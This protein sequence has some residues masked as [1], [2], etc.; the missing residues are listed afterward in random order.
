[1]QALIIITGPSAVGKTT[2]AKLLFN[3]FSNLKSAVTYTTREPRT[4]SQEDKLI[5]HVTKNE[6]KALIKNNKLIEWAE[7][8]GEFYG[9]GKEELLNILEQSPVLLNIDVQGAKNIKQ[10]FPESLSFFIQ[11]DNL[12]I[13]KNRIDARPIPQNIK[14]KRWQ[15]AKEEMAQKTAFDYQITNT[16]GQLS[17][18]VAKIS[19][20]LKEKLNF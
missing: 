13:L 18:T 1:M 2:V 15:A 10:Q 5:H 16:D 4:W 11:P 17:E 9:T 6:F 12:E 14:D 7:V 3:K 8:Y 19:Q 20:I